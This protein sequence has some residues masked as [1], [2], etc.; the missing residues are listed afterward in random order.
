MHPTAGLVH[1]PR[2][3]PEYINGYLE[4]VLRTEA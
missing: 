2:A 4:Q 1:A 3:Y